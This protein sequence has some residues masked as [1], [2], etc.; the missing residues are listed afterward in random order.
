MANAAPNLIS[1]PEYRVFL[2][3]TKHIHGIDF[4]VA[5]GMIYG[6][7]LHSQIIFL[8]RYIENYIFV[9]WKISCKL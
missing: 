6:L 2:A 1:T 8:Y 9:Y 7:A 3:N 4:Q 5:D